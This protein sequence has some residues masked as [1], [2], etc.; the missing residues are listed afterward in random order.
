MWT[1]KRERVGAVRLLP[2]LES[3]CDEIDERLASIRE[4]ESKRGH[5]RRF[6]AR[7][8]GRIRALD[9]ELETHRSELAHAFDELRTLDCMV[10]GMDPVTIRIVDDNGERRRSYL[11][12]SGD[13]ALSA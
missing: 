4:L 8:T 3:I 6:R 1:R 12:R 5:L 13:R 9:A 11:W 10:I 7:E 2:L